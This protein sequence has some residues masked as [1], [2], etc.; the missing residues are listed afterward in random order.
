M[1]LLLV[2]D[3]QE[4]LDH[5]SDLTKI[6]RI[7]KDMANVMNAL[8]MPLNIY[9]ALVGVIVWTQYNEIDMDTNGDRMLTNFLRYRKEKLLKNHPND[10]A[11]LL[12]G[13]VFEG[14][15]KVHYTMI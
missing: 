3:R 8:Y 12:T 1:E 10:H 9:I 4:Y 14:E 7:C 13:I 6:Y 15:E 11:Q 5:G 2:V